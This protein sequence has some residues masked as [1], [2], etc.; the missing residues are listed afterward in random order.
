MDGDPYLGKGELGTF[1]NIFR[2]LS[3]AP[4]AQELCIVGA[5]RLFGSILAHCINLNNDLAD[6]SPT[7]LELVFWAQHPK[8][9]RGYHP[10]DCITLNTNQPL[11]WRMPMPDK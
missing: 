2:S 5:W 1:A 7:T 9:E 3:I 11:G 6:N 4:V 8:Q 10:D